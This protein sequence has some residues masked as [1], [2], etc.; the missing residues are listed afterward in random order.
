MTYRASADL[1]E[2]ATAAS[3]ATSKCYLK[4]INLNNSEIAKLQ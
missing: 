4:Y 1:Q 3:F 2:L